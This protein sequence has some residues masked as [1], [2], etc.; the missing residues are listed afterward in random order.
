MGLLPAEA[1]VESKW[2]QGK[3]LH[4]LIMK[5]SIWFPV[6]LVTAFTLGAAA[7]TPSAPVPSAPEPAGAPTAPEPAGV[8]AATVPSSVG[9]A[10]IA[11]LAF[12]VAVMDT[13]EFKRDF[14]DLQKK[15]QPKKDALKAL[16][17]DVDALTKQLQAHG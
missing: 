14:A 15:Y 8:S 3:E 13:N 5:R 6:A 7:Q 1:G 11:V 16:G 12:Q 17:N 9:P 4:K 10:R 2:E